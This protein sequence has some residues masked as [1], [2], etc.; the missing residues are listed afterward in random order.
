M[1]IRGRDCDIV[2]HNNSKYFVDGAVDSS[3]HLQRIRI[4]AI[5]VNEISDDEID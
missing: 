2:K 1:K 5:E 3:T 4:E